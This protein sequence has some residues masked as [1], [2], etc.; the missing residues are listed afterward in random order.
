M[1]GHQ[2]I[3]SKY[4][5]TAISLIFHKGYQLT[6]YD[7][8]LQSEDNPLVLVTALGPK[9]ANLLEHVN[10]EPLPDNINKAMIVESSENVHTTYILLIRVPL[11]QPTFSPFPP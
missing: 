1:T 7:I 2:I 4:L 10:F 6:L 3:A 9:E 8:E 11:M 5:I